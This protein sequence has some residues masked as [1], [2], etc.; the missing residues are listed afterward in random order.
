[1]DSR[2]MGEDYI[3]VTYYFYI[4]WIVDPWEEITSLCLSIYQHGTNVDLA[5]FL[6]TN[7][8]QTI[9]RCTARHGSIFMLA[10]H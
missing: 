3:S 1:M 2:P 7:F 9:C 8:T 4:T 10:I 5:Y 6:K